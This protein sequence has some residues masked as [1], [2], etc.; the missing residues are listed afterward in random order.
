MKNGLIYYLSCLHLIFHLLPAVVSPAKFPLRLALEQMIPAKQN[1]TQRSRWVTF[2]S[3]ALQTA[4]WI[5]KLF[6][7]PRLF[8]FIN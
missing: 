7:W 8:A 4:E 5:A 2:R 3:H 6:G 1:H